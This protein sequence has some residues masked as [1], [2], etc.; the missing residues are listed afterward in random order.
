[1]QN[2]G[3]IDKKT[4]NFSKNIKQKCIQTFSYTLTN[5][6]LATIYNGC[7]CRECEEKSSMVRFL[8]S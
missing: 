6:N 3:G 7:G 1:M 4:G 5:G 2:N 8:F